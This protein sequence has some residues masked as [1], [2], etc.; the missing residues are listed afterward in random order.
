MPT[1]L[2]AKL[3]QKSR[4][5]KPSVYQTGFGCHSGLRLQTQ[6]WAGVGTIVR[7]TLPPLISCWKVCPI[8]CGYNLTLKHRRDIVNAHL[9][10]AD[11]DA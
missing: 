1:S 5:P 8:L 7:R 10:T 2:F 9:E 11:Y 6:R 3:D 4:R